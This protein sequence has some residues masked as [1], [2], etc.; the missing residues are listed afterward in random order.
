[1]LRERT[2]RQGCPWSERPTKGPALSKLDEKGTVTD[3]TVEF[4][5]NYHLCG[6]SQATSKCITFLRTR[7]GLLTPHAWSQV[8]HVENYIYIRVSYLQYHHFGGQGIQVG[9]IMLKLSG[10]CDLS[11][12]IALYQYIG[13]FIYTLHS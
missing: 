9:H 12:P 5:T 11:V 3:I 6:P 10:I 4:A 1:M 7:G 8:Y 13:R 2:E